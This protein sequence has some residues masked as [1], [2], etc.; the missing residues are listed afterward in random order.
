MKQLESVSVTQSSDKKCFSNRKFDVKDIDINEMIDT[1]KEEYID[2]DQPDLRARTCEK[3]TTEW[4]EKDQLKL[5]GLESI[6]KEFP[7]ITTLE[8]KAI[9]K[10][11]YKQ[12]LAL[13]GLAK[14]QQK[15]AF[16]LIEESMDNARNKLS[17]LQ[18]DLRKFKIQLDILKKMAVLDE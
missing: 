5:S 13:A 1:A 15:S 16:D 17:E 4:R 2:I 18:G 14:I 3:P 12:V 7:E 10:G 6:K 9:Y 11:T 8:E